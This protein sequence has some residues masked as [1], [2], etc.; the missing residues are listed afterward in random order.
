MRT[1]RRPEPSGL[2][3]SAQPAHKMICCRCELMATEIKSV[4]YRRCR[5]GKKAVLDLAFARRMG[6]LPPIRIYRR[7]R[8]IRNLAM[9]GAFNSDKVGLPRF[10]HVARTVDA[11]ARR[12]LL[13]YDAG[14]VASTAPIFS[15]R[16]T[17][18]RFFTLI[19]EVIYRRSFNSRVMP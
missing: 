5:L 10:H 12:R 2:S 9:A 15:A 14:G 18:L 4:G 13:M 11:I 7:N 17:P 1:L 8:S 6:T 19:K 3:I 16:L